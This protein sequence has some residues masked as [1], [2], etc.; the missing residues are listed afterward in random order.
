[1]IYQCVGNAD[2][3]LKEIMKTIKDN[4]KGKS[5]SSI[6][7]YCTNMLSQYVLFTIVGLS[8][9]ESD[10]VFLKSGSNHHQSRELSGSP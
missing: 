3:G 7:K 10:G 1:M 4:L 6:I 5:D 8:K 2:I 9:S